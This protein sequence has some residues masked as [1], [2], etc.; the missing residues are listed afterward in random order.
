VIVNVPPEPTTAIVCVSAVAIEPG[1]QVA[2]AAVPAPPVRRA[3]SV[4]G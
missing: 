3:G 2:T 4:V 1:V